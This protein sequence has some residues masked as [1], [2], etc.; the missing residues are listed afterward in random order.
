VPDTAQVSNEVT[1]PRPSIRMNSTGEIPLADL[2]SDS[3]PL[4]D[5]ESDSNMMASA[6]AKKPAAPDCKNNPD[7]AKQPH[8]KNLV[9]KDLSIVEDQAR[10]T[11]NG[12]TTDPIS[13]A[14]HFGRL[15]TAMA[16]TRNPS[17]FVEGWLNE[18]M[19]N[20]NIVGDS[21][22]DIPARVGMQGILSNWPRI[23]GKLDLT[24]APFRL[25]AIVNRIDLLSDNDAGEGRFIF[26]LVGGNGDPKSIGGTPEQ[27]TV[28]L[29]YR[30]L[31]NSNLDKS[32]W[33]TRWA[34]LEKHTAWRTGPDPAS[35][36]AYKQQLTLITN[37]FALKPVFEINGSAI[38]QIRTNEIRLAAPWQLREFKLNT[39]GNLVSAPIAFTPRPQLNNQNDLNSILAAQ[40]DFILKG[41][42]I[43][44]GNDHQGAETRY[45]PD[46]FWNISNNGVQVPQQVRFLFSLNTCNGCHAAETGTS[47][48]HVKP[49]A[50]N[51]ESAMSGFMSGITVTDPATQNLPPPQ[52]INRTFNELSSRQK[53]ISRFL[54]DVG[55]TMSVTQQGVV[56]LGNGLTLAAQK[57]TSSIRVSDT[58]TGFVLGNITGGVN[59]PWFMTALLMDNTKITVSFELPAGSNQFVPSVLL[60]TRGN[61][62]V[63]VDNLNRFIGQPLLTAYSASGGQSQDAG[64]PDGTTVPSLW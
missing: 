30:L 33:L 49:R 16:G 14:W 2:E 54:C 57:N 41:K 56:N 15:M 50:F 23:N 26:G 47:F 24:K 58:K 63:R 46:S 3:N 27:F 25:L 44:L 17:D 13:G 42:P 51:T 34:E 18:W 29:E 22:I 11:W 48:T 64:F 52:Q 62:F 60:V 59:K 7:L 38:A 35:L 19:T 39:Q 20:K 1:P 45:S 37:N 21:A 31:A 4:A 10:T 8:I 36:N 5:L 28:I 32:L 61:E 12:S 9:I 40:S 53:V 6:A 43:M 55:A